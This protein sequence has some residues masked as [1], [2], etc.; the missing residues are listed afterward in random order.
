M[1]ACTLCNEE[2]KEKKSFQLLH[3]WNLLWHEPKWHQDMIKLVANKSSQ[4]KCKKID[5]F[6]LDLTGN[7]NDEMTN[8][9]NNGNAT[10]DGDRPKRPMGRKKGKQL[11]H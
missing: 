1:D 2:D 9:D 8:T 7:P 6:V 4:K 3:C 11:L 10:L 5:D